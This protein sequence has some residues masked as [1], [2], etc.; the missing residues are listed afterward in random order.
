MTLATVRDILTCDV[1]WGEDHLNST[2]RYGCA[3]DLMSDVLAFSQSEALLLTG[4]V[5]QQT[6]QTAF[7]ADIR[8]IVF[9]RGKRPHG[10][11]VALAAEKGI[12]LLGTGYSMFESCGILY[13]S[14]LPSTMPRVS[15][16]KASAVTKGLDG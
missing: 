12:P 5:T 6:V 16:A 4:L 7:V 8:A 3:S 1:Y 13:R 9:V 15:S 14:G 10:D 2:V 11:V